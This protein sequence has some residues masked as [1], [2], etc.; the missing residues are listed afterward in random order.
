MV[1]GRKRTQEGLGCGV[2][3]VHE[4]TSKVI[5]VCISTGDDVWWAVA[6]HGKVSLLPP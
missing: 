5:D 1:L 4:D 6:A 2:S 3:R